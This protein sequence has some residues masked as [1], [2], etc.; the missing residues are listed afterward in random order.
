MNYLIK[1][2]AIYYG[3]SRREVREFA[4]QCAKRL[5]LEY[6][7]S[8]DE[9]KSASKD[10]YYGYMHRHPQ[11]S[12]R[13][14][15]QISANRSKGFNETNVN[16]FY[17]NLSEVLDDGKFQPQQIWNIDETACP[18]V[19]TKPIKVIA[20]KGAKRVGQKT[21]AERGTTVSLAVAINASGQSIPPFYIF[22]RVMQ[23]I[24]FI[25]F[26]F[27][28]IN[29]IFLYIL[30]YFVG[31]YATHFLGR[32]FARFYWYCLRIR[33]DERSW[34]HKIHGALH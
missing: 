9:N 19:P 26:I 13:T 10:W 31:E 34:I 3:L 18:S 15:D 23:R 1:A 33:L 32:C 2:N 11:L 20:M 14:P 24:F 22:P 25:Q 21:S 28:F 12:L 17:D 7:A 30:Y 5:K 27:Y 6:P 29:F 4:Y 8:W 16:R